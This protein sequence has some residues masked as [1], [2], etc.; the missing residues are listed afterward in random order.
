MLVVHTPRNTHIEVAAPSVFLGGTI[1][2]GKSFDW[3]RHV[4]DSMTAYRLNVYNPR[5][6]G[7]TT[8]DDEEQTYQIEWEL[9]YLDK[10]D[11]VMMVFLDGSKAPISFLELGMLLKSA[12]E[13]LIVVCSENFYRAKNVHITCKQHGVT[14]VSTI[15]EAVMILKTRLEKS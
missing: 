12:P 6:P 9:F 15:S 4:I 2:M 10:V 5:R 3:Q 14:P 11:H 1:D 13:K 8:F 7:F